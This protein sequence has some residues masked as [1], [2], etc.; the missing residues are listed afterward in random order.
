MIYAKEDMNENVEPKKLTN[1][2]K[3]P[4]V[5]D[6]RKDLLEAE[7]AHSTAVTKINRYLDNLYVRNEAAPKKVSGRSSVQPKLIRKQ[8]EWLYAA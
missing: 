1:W 8:A 7:S 5:S 6:L 2:A 4:K 3:E